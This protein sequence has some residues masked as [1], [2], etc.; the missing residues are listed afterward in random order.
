MNLFATVVPFHADYVWSWV[1]M[2]IGPDVF[3]PLTSALAAMAGFLLMFWHRVLGFVM[4]MLGK[5]GPSE[6]ES[7]TVSSDSA[8]HQKRS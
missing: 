2:Y 4:R 7:H 5:G 6:A 3:L 1:L 8:D